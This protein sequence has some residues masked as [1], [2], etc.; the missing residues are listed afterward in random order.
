[1]FAA[2]VEEL[3]LKEFMPK[4]EA[5][6]WTSFADFAAS[7]SDMKGTDPQLFQTEVI[8]PLIGDDEAKKPKIRRLFMQSYA[9]LSA[10]MEKYSNP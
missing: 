6:G 3:G 8:E 10:E 2:R 4:F 7:C 5:K 9:V 1:M